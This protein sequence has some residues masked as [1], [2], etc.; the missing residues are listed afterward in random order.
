MKPRRSGGIEAAAMGSLD[1]MVAGLG[2]REVVWLWPA[3]TAVHVIEE[4]PCF[5]AWARR[6]A[7]ARYSDREYVV[8]HVLT[9]AIAI[10]GAAV[11]STRPS[12]PVVFAGFALGIGSAV[13]WNG[14]F[15]LAATCWSRR[16]CPGVVT[17]VVLYLPFSGWLATLALREGLLT[18]G[19]L[20]TALGIALA[21]H[22]AEVGHT[23]FKRW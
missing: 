20:A 14:C 1:G 18:P 23:V 5:A 17:G 22:V 13:A 2:F 4:W 12:T 7:S 6:F 15:H 19:G 10:G 9:V 21:G 8:T 3:L 11:L 16:Y